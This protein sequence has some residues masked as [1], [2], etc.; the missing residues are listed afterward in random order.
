MGCGAGG[1]DS[2]TTYPAGV[3]IK[4]SE[5]LAYLCDV[6]LEAGEEGFAEELAEPERPELE[7]ILVEA[8]DALLDAEEQHKRELRQLAERLSK[9]D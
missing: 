2:A 9:R 4:V 8:V 3:D 7:A 1:Y 5:R 6:R